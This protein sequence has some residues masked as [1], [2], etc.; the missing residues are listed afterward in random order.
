MGA[1]A[2]GSF[3]TTL[4]RRNCKSREAQAARN[5]LRDPIA[6]GRYMSEIVTG[7]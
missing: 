3:E 4:F 5:S 2:E 1:S 7:D 6:N